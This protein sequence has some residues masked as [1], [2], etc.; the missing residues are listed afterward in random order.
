MHYVALE[1]YN[2]YD[3]WRSKIYGRDSFTYGQM[4][5]LAEDLAS[6]AASASQV[7]FYHCDFQN[8]INLKTLEVEMALWGHIH[9]NRG[10]I[11]DKPYD[12]ATNNLCD[13]ER[14][15][16]LVRVSGG[17]LIPSP[18]VSAGYDGNDL[19]VEYEPANDG[20]HNVVTATIANDHYER[21]E[22][23]MLRFRL[24]EASDSAE[25]T[26][27]TL[28]RIEDTGAYATYCV[29]V[30]IQPLASQQVTV[31]IDS[32]STVPDTTEASSTLWLGP[33]RPNP[34][35]S[36]TSL[37]FTLPQAGLARLAV[38]DIR[39]R[40]VAVL[41]DRHLSGGSHGAEWNGRDRNSKHVSAGVYFARLTVAD[42]ERVSKLVLMR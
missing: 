8:Q 4:Q 1:A 21:F 9:R 24:P 26:G 38:F 2:N 42:G 30:D 17:T 34:F 28:I 19:S 40:E 37:N 10:S 36:Q 27:G 29:G 5:W 39:G 18:T 7:L 35:I 14:S 23:A 15:Y 31:A 6:A 41:V 13:G 20:T 12:L 11:T 16:R 25:V 3:R 33:S 32:T 22:H